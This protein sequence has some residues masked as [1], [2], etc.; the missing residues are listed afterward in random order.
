MGFGKDG[1]GVIIKEVFTLSLDALAA[2]TAVKVPGAAITDDMR[3][4]KSMIH[5]S[6]EGLTAGEGNNLLFGICNDDLSA[7][8]I[9]ASL[10]AGGPLNRADRDIAELAERFT[11]VLSGSGQMDDGNTI[12]HF[13]GFHN[14]PVIQEVI[15][16]T[17]TK[18]VGWA[19]Y[20]F[21]HDGSALTTGATLRLYHQAFGVWVT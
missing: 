8:D 13:T 1:K 7:A 10:S 21:N 19:F 18:G 11:R 2:N 17:F 9:A 4:L 15:R 5:A 3:I 6:V 16:W 12:R 20:I 14:E